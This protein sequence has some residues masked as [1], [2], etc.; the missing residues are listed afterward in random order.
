MSD[1]RRTLGVK[2][3]VYRP[4]WLLVKHKMVFVLY[5]HLNYLPGEHGWLPDNWD[6]AVTARCKIRNRALIANLVA[7]R[8]RRAC[9]FDG[10]VHF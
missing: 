7:R 9:R 1:P 4:R 5:S 2:H 8:P 10:L 3:V 6:I